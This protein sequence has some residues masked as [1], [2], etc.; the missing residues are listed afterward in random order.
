MTKEREALI[1]R[2]QKWLD[3]NPREQIIAAQ[4]AN[5]AEEYAEQLLI[6][7]VSS[8]A[9]IGKA[10]MMQKENDQLIKDARGHWDKEYKKA[11]GIGI[12][13]IIKLIKRHYC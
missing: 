2:F 4:C 10:E 11:I 12:D 3:T 9:L 1:D 13:R 7:R 8:S 5:I 6:Q